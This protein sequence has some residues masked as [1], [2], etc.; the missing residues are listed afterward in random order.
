M[1]TVTVEN[2]VELINQLPALERG[3]LIN[4]LTQAETVKPQ[5]PKSRI[6]ST[7]APYIDRTREDAWLKQHRNE[8]IGKWIALNGD[9]LV[10]QGETGRE[11]FAK[12]REM[13]IDSALVILVEDP[14]IHYMGL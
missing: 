14:D 9:E 7:N 11:V 12:I 3:K 8:Y 13:G 1:A 6:I 4:E 10:A 2:I 5:F